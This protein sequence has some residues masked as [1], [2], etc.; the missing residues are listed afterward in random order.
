M[1]GCIFDIDG[2]MFLNREFHMLAWKQ[3]LR[4]PYERPFTEDEFAEHMFGP[5][6]ESIIHWLFNG[7]LSPEESL[8]L[9]LKKE[10]AYRDACRNN[11]S[12]HLT[13]GLPL[14]LDRLK[15]LNCSLG[16]A[17]GAPI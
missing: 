15:A 8:A 5:T 6:N 13:N 14:F 4:G 12:A 7:R 16:I 1:K 11:G 9:S 3:C 10:S 2:T 17:T